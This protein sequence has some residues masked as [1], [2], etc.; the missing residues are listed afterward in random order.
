M[1][2]QVI[3]M[4][5]TSFMVPSSSKGDYANAIRGFRYVTSGERFILNHPRGDVI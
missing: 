3:N 4:H 2:D 1:V 5:F